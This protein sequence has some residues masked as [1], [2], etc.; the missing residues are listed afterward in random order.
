MI[1]PTRRAVM[2]MAA[3]VP[4]A[5]LAG[6]LTPAGWLAGP[7]WIAGLLLLVVLDAAPG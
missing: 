1:Y 7:V 6:V 4:V 5:L 2:V 3:G